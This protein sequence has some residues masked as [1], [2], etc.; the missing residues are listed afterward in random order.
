MK[1]KLEV[2]EIYFYRV[3]NFEVLNRMHKQKELLLTVKERQNIMRSEKY[4][5]LRVIIV[6]KI[7]GRRSINRSLSVYQMRCFA[8]V[9]QKPCWPIESPTIARGERDKKKLWYVIKYFYVNS[10]II[11]TT[12][13][14]WYF[15]DL[16]WTCT[17]K[18][19]NGV[20]YSVIPPISFSWYFY[21]LD[22]MCKIYNG[23]SLKNI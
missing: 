8:W 22:W 7:P 17:R 19:Y 9:Y 11:L 14:T 13:F 18:I 15:Y 12:S 20:N 23:V 3:T 10:Y 2:F 4:E 5:L 16:S 21:D 6:G 1:R